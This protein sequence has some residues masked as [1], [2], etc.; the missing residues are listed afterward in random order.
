MQRILKAQTF[1]KNEMSYMMGSKILE[2]NPNNKII[3]K[4]KHRLDL[5]LID[6]QLSELVTVLYNLT[7][8]SSG[9]TLDNPSKFNNSVLNLIDDKL[10][11]SIDESTNSS[12]S[13]SST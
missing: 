6:T 11:M 4:I 5:E 12:Q 9:F 3:Q 10:N 13:A 7:L 2:I 8:Q 1:N